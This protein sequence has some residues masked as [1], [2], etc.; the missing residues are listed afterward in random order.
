M[1]SHCWVETIMMV[2][3]WCVRCESFP[4]DHIPSMIDLARKTSKMDDK[5]ETHKQWS[6]VKFLAIHTKT[7]EAYTLWWNGRTFWEMLNYNSKYS[8]IMNNHTLL[9]QGGPNMNG[10]TRL[11]AIRW[12]H[13]KLAWA[14]INIMNIV[15]HHGILHNNLSKNNIM[16]H[17]PPN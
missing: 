16:L 6:M 17:F 4:F 7:M 13:V 3:M 9:R 14:F 1:C 12:N 2:M 10:Q 8:P 15:H 5:Q 11:V